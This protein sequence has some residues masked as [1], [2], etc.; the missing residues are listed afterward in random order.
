MIE[1]TMGP[2]ASLQDLARDTEHCDFHPGS[3]C[4]RC[5]SPLRLK[6]D[7]SDLCLVHR[8]PFLYC[9]GWPNCEFATLYSPKAAN[10]TGRP[11]WMP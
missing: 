9:E 6:D 8:L 4:P 3:K 10:I 11:E 1:G 7:A 2:L 5:G